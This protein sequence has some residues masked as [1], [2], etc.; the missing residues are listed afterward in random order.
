M[1]EGTKAAHMRAN[2]ASAMSLAVARTPEP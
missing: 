2:V 1:A